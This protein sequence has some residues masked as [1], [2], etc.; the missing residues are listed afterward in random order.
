[1][2]F[3]LWLKPD[4]SVTAEKCDHSFGEWT[5]VLETTCTQVGCS[6]RECS[7]CGFVQYEFTECNGHDW[8]DGVLV[9]QQ[10]CVNHGLIISTCETCGQ[11]RALVLDA[12]GHSF[13]NGKCS[14]CGELEST[15]RFLQYSLNEDGAS[16]SVKLRPSF[17]NSVTH[18]SIPATFD[19]KPV[20]AL[21]SSAFSGCS[22]LKQIYLTEGLLSIGNYAFMNCQNLETVNIPKSVVS[23]GHNPFLM[24]NSVVVNLESKSDFKIIDGALIDVKSKTLISGFSSTSIPADGSV[25]AIGNNAF[26][27]AK[28][29][30]IAIPA[31]ITSIGYG[32]F[33]VANSTFDIYY[34]GSEAQWNNVQIEDNAYRF[35]TVVHFDV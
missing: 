15:D 6:S 29:T 2:D 3:L 14:A 35:N 17:R 27:N 31:T 7:K 22:Y 25:T 18:I 33:L 23:I 9:I 5:E 12:L 13:E 4:Y 28:L 16:Y 1:A 11:T 34:D 24:S 32:A 21:D 20:T 10:D 8:G 30:E 26:C 19:G